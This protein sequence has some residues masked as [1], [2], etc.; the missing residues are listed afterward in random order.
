MLRRVETISDASFQYFLSVNNQ[1]NL[2]ELRT[3]SLDREI[4]SRFHIQ[5]VNFTLCPQFV[6]FLVILLCIFYQSLCRSHM[7][8]RKWNFL[9]KQKRRLQIQHTIKHI[10]F[11]YIIFSV[12]FFNLN[13]IHPNAQPNLH[14]FVISFPISSI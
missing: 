5:H 14:F 1:A 13:F 6:Y 9:P 2:F 11:A 7:K 3:N 12:Y 4:T 8:H 10:K